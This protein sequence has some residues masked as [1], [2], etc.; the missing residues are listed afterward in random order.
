LVGPSG[1][2]KSTLLNILTKLSIPN[3]GTITV[4]DQKLEDINFVDV[5]R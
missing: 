1:T 2:G 5:H 4:G 3:A